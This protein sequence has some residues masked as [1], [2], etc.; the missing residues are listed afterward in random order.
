M[1]KCVL[2]DKEAEFFIKGT[3]DGYCKECAE[4]NFGDISYLITAEDQARALKK[5]IEEKLPDIDEE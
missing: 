4:D 5:A 1:G 2:C 3:N